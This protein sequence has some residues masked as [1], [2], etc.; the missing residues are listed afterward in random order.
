[1]PDFRTYWQQKEAK[2]RENWDARYKSFIAKHCSLEEIRETVFRPADYAWNFAGQESFLTGG[3]LHRLSGTR[4]E[5]SHRVSQ[6][7]AYAMGGGIA[8]SP[9]S[10]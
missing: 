3:T 5:C 1:M 4:V 10:G 8:Q 2:L 6:V 7:D 9:R